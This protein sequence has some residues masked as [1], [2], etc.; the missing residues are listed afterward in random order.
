MHHNACVFLATAKVKIDDSA[1][2]LAAITDIY[3]TRCCNDFPPLILTKLLGVVPYETM[4]WFHRV[5]GILRTPPIRISDGRKSFIISTSGCNDHRVV[6]QLALWF[7]LDH[8]DIKEL[9]V[10]V[11]HFSKEI[12][13]MKNN[14]IPLFIAQYNLHSATN[15]IWDKHKGTVRCVPDCQPAN[16]QHVLTMPK[17]SSLKFSCAQEL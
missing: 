15:L 6:G 1:T 7:N 5:Y 9:A 4:S 17:Q 14:N 12:L 13:Y 11:A 8:D 10:A 16:S 3:T 2:C